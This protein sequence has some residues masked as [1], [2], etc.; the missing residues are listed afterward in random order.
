MG[1]FLILS[2]LLFFPMASMEEPQ[3][4]RSLAAITV[5]QYPDQ[6][7]AAQ[8]VNS[9]I[10]AILTQKILNAQIKPALFPLKFKTPKSSQSVV[11]HGVC[12]L[13]TISKTNQ[14]ISIGCDGKIA[15]CDENPVHDCQVIDTHKSWYC[16]C[17]KCDTATLCLGD[18]GGNIG[19]MNLNDKIPHR[20]FKAHQQTINALALS[21][22]QQQLVSCSNDWQV[23][24]W[25][26]ASN[27]NLATFLGHSRA[28][29]NAFSILAYQKIV[30][31]S[32]DQTIRVWD[33][34]TSKEL[35]CYSLRDT[36]LHGANFFRLA[37]HPH[38]Q[39]A[40]SGLTNGIIALW[41]I[42]KKRHVECLKRHTSIVSALICSGDGNY[43]ASA[44][45]DGKIRLWDL[46]MMACSA[47]LSYH[48]D[49]VLSVASLHNFNEIV[50]G[51]RDGT[52]KRW[53]VSSVLAIDQMNILKEVVAKAALIK[54]E[55]P[56]SDEERLAMLKKLTQ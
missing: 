55:N 19:Y 20:I 28:V 44:S 25:E 27:K 42:R 22:N 3:S 9:D 7:E 53:D 15:I 35:Q 1:L 43:I 13:E 16:A 31:A 2:C 50:S 30:S 40:V 45:W 34:W 24:L 23:K 38:E 52:V 49:W 18:L 56:I 36:L 32:A 14:V 6:L 39:F 29:K 47:I 11:H 17:L 46:R 51:A 10:Q 12:C 37:K 8:S 54:Q 41:D 26:I 48:K 21:P 5:L 4:L 33:I